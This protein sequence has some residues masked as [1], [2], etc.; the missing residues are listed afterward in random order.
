MPSS[1]YHFIDI[2]QIR[3]GLYIHLDLGWMDHPFTFSNFKI[4][5]AEQIAKIREIGI[6]KLR[7][8]PKRSDCEPMPVGSSP[9]LTVMPLTEDLERTKQKRLREL[10]LAIDESEKKFLL[11]TQTVRQALRNLEEKPEISILQA[12]QLVNDLAHTVITEPDIAVHAINGNRSA[13]ENYLHQV[14]VTML[15]LMLCKSL[16]MIEADAKAIGLAAIFHDIGKVKISDAIMLKETPLSAEELAEMRKHCEYGAQIAKESGLSE[17]ISKVILQH[18]EYSDGSGYPQALRDSAIDPLAR[19]ISIVSAYD[20]L[21][22]PQHCGH[23]LTPYEAL[24]HMFSHQRSKYDE[25]ILKQFIKS[26]GVYPPGSV[27]QLSN[28]AHAIVIS[29]NPRKP[30]KPFVMVHDPDKER[31]VPMVIDLREEPALSISLCLRPHQLPPESL[32]YLNP[33]QRVSYFVDKEFTA[34]RP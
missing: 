23:A 28:G 1:Q 20:N 19:L 10:H 27:V 33:R 6:K 21:C 14:N 16:S 22:N 32:I 8:D 2:S 17:R 12:Q 7:Y 15:S 11:A 5:D 31:D 13:D 18:H 24:S 26:L 9:E 3:I 4:K 34:S 30:L 29:V 25:W